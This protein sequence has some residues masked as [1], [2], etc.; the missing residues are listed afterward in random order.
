MLNRSIIATFLDLQESPREDAKLFKSLLSILFEDFSRHGLQDLELTVFVVEAEIFICQRPHKVV[1]HLWLVR[2]HEAS[3]D[4][5]A[6]ALRPE[7]NLS[8][9]WSPCGWL[10]RHLCDDCSCTLSTLKLDSPG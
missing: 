2:L 4:A 7:D 9:V 3:I 8:H 6:G 5:L 1:E 10:F